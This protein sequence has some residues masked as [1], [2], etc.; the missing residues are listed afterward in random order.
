MFG[1][2]THASDVQLVGACIDLGLPARFSHTPSE[3]GDLRDVKSLVDLLV[4]V[5]CKLE[6]G[7]DL[8][9]GAAMP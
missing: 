9:R 5:V 3:S 7:V 4:A 8:G 2:L 6:P 1:G